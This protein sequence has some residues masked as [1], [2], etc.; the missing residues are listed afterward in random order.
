MLNTKSTYIEQSNGYFYHQPSVIESIRKTVMKEIRQKQASHATEAKRLIEQL[1]GDDLKVKI[2]EKPSG[3]LTFSD[4]YKGLSLYRHVKFQ[5]IDSIYKGLM[6]LFDKP[7]ADNLIRKMI[8]KESIDENS[9]LISPDARAINMNSLCVTFEN[10]RVTWDVKP[11]EN[12]HTS[13]LTKIPVIILINNLRLTNW[14]SVG[15]KSYGGAIVYRKMKLDD[16][17][18][19]Y[20]PD[21]IAEQRAKFILNFGE[22][23][24]NMIAQ[25]P[26]KAS[27]PEKKTT[28]KVFDGGLNSANDQ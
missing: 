13:M 4:E 15:D 6:K 23:G 2:T 1:V 28:F 10:N 20:K 24:T 14:D 7:L 21:N 11:G 22:V 27:S 3:V 8:A 9:Y 16:E 26:G 18:G 5:K 25:N 17:T 19:E 12:T